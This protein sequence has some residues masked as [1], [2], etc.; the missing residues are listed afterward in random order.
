M[1][2]FIARVGT[3]V[4]IMSHSLEG[5]NLLVVG[6][7]GDVGACSAEDVYLARR[8]TCDECLLFW[9]KEQFGDI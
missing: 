3:D 6:K 7:C 5:Q 2:T 8:P 4:H 1:K 9:A